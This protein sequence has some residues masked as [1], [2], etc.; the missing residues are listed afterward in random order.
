[1][2]VELDIVLISKDLLVG[3]QLSAIARQCQRAF[4]Q[5]SSIADRTLQTSGLSLVLVDLGQIDPT[6]LI[7]FVPLV[8]ANSPQ[9]KILAFG[10]HVHGERLQAARDAG[11][12]FLSHRGGVVAQFKS[13]LGGDGPPQ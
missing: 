8:R 13:I 10:P 5:V 9:V 12:D 11:C 6:M 4:R 7:D 2:D 3:S 1:M